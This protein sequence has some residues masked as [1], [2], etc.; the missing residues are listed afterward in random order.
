MNHYKISL[1]LENI[2]W[3]Y[4]LY[5]CSF[6]KKTPRNGPMFIIGFVCFLKHSFFYI[7]LYWISKEY[8]KISQESFYLLSLFAGSQKNDALVNPYWRKGRHY[9]YSRQAIS[10]L[11]M[12][13]NPRTPT[14][15]RSIYLVNT[16]YTISFWKTLFSYHTKSKQI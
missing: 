14:L 2:K 10:Y 9:L 5:V 6:S 8:I 3:G 7:D 4:I 13:F 1:G 12:I 16:I 11:D 15:H